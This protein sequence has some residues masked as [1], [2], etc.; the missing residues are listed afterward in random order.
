MACAVVLVTL[1]DKQ[2]SSY[3]LYGVIPKLC[4]TSKM[5]ERNCDQY[6]IHE[7]IMDF[8]FSMPKIQYNTTLIHKSFT[9]YHILLW[10]DLCVNPWASLSCFGYLHIKVSAMIFFFLE[11]EKRIFLNK[12]ETYRSCACKQKK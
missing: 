4:D 8:V 10:N 2:I 3:A 9:F 7:I 1:P 5:T 11:V 12:S 6:L